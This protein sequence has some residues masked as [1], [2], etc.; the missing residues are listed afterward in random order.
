MWGSRRASAPAL[1]EVG[2]E[3]AQWPVP[4]LCAVLYQQHLYFSHPSHCLGPWRPQR[5]VAVILVPSAITAPGNQNPPPLEEA[6]KRHWERGG[7]PSLGVGPGC[8]STSLYQ[9]AGRHSSAGNTTAPGAPGVSFRWQR[10][11]T[12]SGGD[13]ASL[14]LSFLLCKLGTRLTGLP[15]LL[16]G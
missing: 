14:C 10:S 9:Q 1:S 11:F 4:S 12:H 16:S 8:L 5:G 2:Y 13:F 7:E 6:Q 3:C 15:E